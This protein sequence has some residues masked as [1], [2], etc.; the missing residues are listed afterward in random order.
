MIIRYCRGFLMPSD[1]LL[2]ERG[3]WV[4]GRRPPRNAMRMLVLA[5]LLG[6][7]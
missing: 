5:A 4:F 1:V 2:P 7:R 3:A 6:A